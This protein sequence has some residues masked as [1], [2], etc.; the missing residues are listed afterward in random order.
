MTIEYES[1]AMLVTHKTGIVDI[2]TII[3]LQEL[4][5]RELERLAACQTDIDYFDDCIANAEASVGE[6]TLPT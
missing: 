6:P 3:E 2:Y 4:R 5:A 1:G